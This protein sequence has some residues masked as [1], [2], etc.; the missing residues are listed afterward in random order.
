MKR[1]IA[2]A[3]FAVLAFVVLAFVHPALAQQK[4]VVAAR[5]AQQEAYCSSGK[6]QQVRFLSDTVGAPRRPFDVLSFKLFLDW[7]NVFAHQTQIFSGHN[8]IS[9]ALTDTT[10]QVLL[11]ASEMLIDTVLVNGV[12]LSV[13]PQPDG[14]SQLTIPLP[15]NLRAKGTAITLDIAYHRTETTNDGMYFYPKGLYVGPGQIG[16][17]VF[18]EENLAYT[19]SEPLDAHKWMPCMDLPYDKANSAISIC[20]PAGYKAQSNGLL[21][22]VVTNSD[23]SQT[24]NWKSDRQL[25]TYLMVAD[26]SN[27]IE[28]S[29]EYHRVSDPNDSVRVVYYAW[30]V[31][32]YQTAVTDGSKYNAQYALRRT[33]EMLAAF[34]RRF[35]EYPFKEYGQ[36]PIQPF[37]YGGMEHQTMTSITRRWLRGFDED[38]IAHELMHQWFGDKT[39]CE[40]W[41]DIWLNEG[42][43]SY[44]EAVWQESLNGDE[45]YHWVMSGKADGFFQG[46]NLDMPVYNPPIDIIFNYATTYAKG[47]CVL[48]MMRRAIDDDTTFFGALRDYS[49]AFAYT[50]ANTYQFRDFMEARLGAKFPVNFSEFIDEWIFTGGYPSYQIAWRQS[51]DN[52]LTIRVV[53]TQAS[54]DHYTM[55]L[56]FRTV[57]T[58]DTS[59]AASEK[60]MVTND[61]RTQFFT[62]QL[63]RPISNLVFDSSAVILSKYSVTHDATF[64][65]VTS[66]VDGRYLAVSYEKGFTKLSFS[67]IVSSGATVRLIDALGRVVEEQNVSSTVTSIRLPET[68]LPNGNYFVILSDGQSVQTAK[69]QILR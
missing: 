55:P 1:Y 34:S 16:D 6:Q 28:W 24:F 40:T 26:A 21:E 20:V 14:A 67:P 48:H 10:S 15:A 42:F 53:Q 5:P 60:F 3:S 36:V 31:D 9:L 50:T 13:L 47:A 25:S 17:S 32:Y 62:V 51:E 65:G 41:A 19:M 49:N 54:R 29:D 58:G 46:Q 57:A 45:G 39:T 59:L 2:F 52:R 8:Q 7:R 22:S 68:G 43:A 69:V 63:D 4:P 56:R 33:P 30:P 11:D 64:S 12:S 61:K 18:V 38:G 27:F 44:G 66:L 37:N 35:G 23:G